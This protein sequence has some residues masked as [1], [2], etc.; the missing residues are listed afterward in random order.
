MMVVIQCAAGKQ[1]HAGKFFTA[2]G[3]PIL[4]VADPSQAPASQYAYCR[5]DDE[6]GGGDTWRSRLLKYNTETLDNPLGLLPAYQLYSAPIYERLAAHVGLER[7]YILSAGW[8]LIPAWFLT[9]DYDITFNQQA[10]LYKRRRRND[11]YWDFFM[12]SGSIQEPA[13]FFGGKDY[14]PLFCELTKDLSV[15]RV[16]PYC[17]N[18]P[19]DFPDLTYVK[20]ETTRRTNWHYECAQAFADGKLWLPAGQ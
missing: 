13:I 1:H 15:P 11:L 5:P 3:K 7:F 8:G 19:P 14:L 17:S 12:P 9:P 16:V 20:Y 18:E 4:F 6:D 2:E 10:E